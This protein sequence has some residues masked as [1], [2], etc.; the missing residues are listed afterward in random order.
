MSEL[1]LDISAQRSQ[2]VTPQLVEEMDYIFG[3]STGHVENLVHY[4]PQASEK[5]F[6]LREFV[7]ELPAGRK[8]IADP[9]GGSLE[10]YRSCRDEIK[11]GVESI[12]SFADEVAPIE[13]L[14]GR[15]IHPEHIRG[16]ELRLGQLL[17]T[18]VEQLALPVAE[19]E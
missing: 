17:A 6:L 9:I 16:A 2:Q 7:E 4:F 8:D 15:K 13:V 19:L 11:Q 3:L 18:Y 5:I 1:G 12:L 14:L 10:V